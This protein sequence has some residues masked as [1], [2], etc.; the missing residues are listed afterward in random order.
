MFILGFV[1]F[2][3]FNGVDCFFWFYELNVFELGIYVSVI[4]ILVIFGLVL[5]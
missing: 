3:I 4:V 1:C 5:F 2:L